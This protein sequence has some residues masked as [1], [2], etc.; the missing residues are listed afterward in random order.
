LLQ[1]KSEWRI[2]NSGP[3]TYIPGMSLYV[4]QLELGPMQNFVYLIGSTES[5]KCAVIDPAWEIEKVLEQ[6]SADG[7]EVTASLI[8]HTHPDHI[9]AARAWTPRRT[10]TRSRPVGC[11]TRASTSSSTARATCSSSVPIAR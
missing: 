8:T 5:K 11:A 6:A 1:A 10:C 4:K 3:S 9:N 2:A 7:M